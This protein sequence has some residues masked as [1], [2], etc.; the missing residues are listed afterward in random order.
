MTF[1]KTTYYIVSLSA[2][3]LL[4][5]RLL[6]PA[7][8]QSV[9]Q[10]IQQSAG[11]FTYLFDT[12]IPSTNPLPPESL[13][14]KHGWVL[15]PEDE[16]THEFAGD[17]ALLN[18][19]LIAVFRK[20][21]RGADVYLQTPTGP[22][23]RALLAPNAKDFSTRDFSLITILENNLSAVH[24]EVEFKRKETSL[25]VGYRLTL[26]ES[27]ME[28]HPGEGTEVLSIQAQ[29]TSV[30]VPDFF[31]DDMVFTPESAEGPFIS[32]PTESFFIYP[33][34]SGNGLIMCVWESS[35][36]RTRLLFSATDAGRTISGSE[37][38]CIKNKTIWVAFI[39]RADIWYQYSDQAKNTAIDWKPPFPAKWRINIMDNGGF[40]RSFPFS[41]DFILE[42]KGKSVIIYPIDRDRSTPLEVFCP[43]DVMRNTLGVGP[44]Q[45][46]LDA[47]QLGS[48]IHPTPN[49]VTEWVERQFDKKRE[50]RYKKEIEDRL[51]A[52]LGFLRDM[53]DRITQYQN[54]VREIDR[55]CVDLEQSHP[56]LSQPLQE[57]RN[58]IRDME[59]CIASKQEAMGDPESVSRLTAGI[60]AL[61]G[62]EI[63]LE[64]CQQLCAQIREIGAAHDYALSKC[65]MTARWLRE[66]CRTSS[67]ENPQTEKILNPIREKVELILREP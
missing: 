67:I 36:Q 34:D 43:I 1:G 15:V 49:E 41:E 44:C 29:T 11:P 65:R 17:A 33:V 19:K 61:I 57:L 56:E 54:R 39:E 9:N 31:G 7:N 52:M 63:A 58:T 38:Q 46:I 13:N 2:I 22:K 26:G 32:L 5:H 66:Q 62:K 21:S 3:F 60:L 28:I 10:D 27:T 16:T 4:E 30:I 23:Y 53:A 51:Q 47:E 12:G 14:D 59:T 40:S 24:L 20:N 50:V 42:D 6:P 35:R 8:A 25:T 18:D 45:Y 37:I 64:D 55:L 48:D